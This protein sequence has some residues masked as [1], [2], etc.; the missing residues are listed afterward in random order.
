MGNRRLQITLQPEVLRWA[1]E[2]IDFSPEELARK[3]QVKL[4]RAPHLH[5]PHWLPLACC[6]S[7]SC[8]RAA[9]FTGGGR[10]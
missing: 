8:A 1:R 10:C 7:S 4:D 5:G 9:A 3:M 6:A 2:R